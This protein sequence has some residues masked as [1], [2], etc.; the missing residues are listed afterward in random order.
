MR[1]DYTNAPV[2]PRRLGPSPSAGTRGTSLSVNQGNTAGR[3]RTASDVQLDSQGNADALA[4]TAKTRQS[5]QGPFGA[6]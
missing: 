3:G 6:R 1:A 5:E 2:D 4:T